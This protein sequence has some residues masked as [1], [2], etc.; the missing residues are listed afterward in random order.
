MEM[1]EES[2]GVTNEMVIVG[3]L[4]VLKKCLNILLRSKLHTDRV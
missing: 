4:T 3:I 2:D 1:W